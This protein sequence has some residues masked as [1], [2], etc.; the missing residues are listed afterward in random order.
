MTKNARNT[1]QNG[2]LQR[3]T[4][5]KGPDVWVFRYRE[6]G[7]LKYRVLG[8]VLQFKTKAAAQQALGDVK[9]N[10]N[11]RL[12]GATFGDL[13]DRYLREGLPER[14]ATAS[15]LRSMVKYR[16]K[17]YWADV[18]VSEMAADPMSVEQWIKNLQ[19]KPRKKD[20][21]PRPL[22]PK[23]KS[24]TKAV[25]HRLFECAMRWRYLTIQRN[26]MSLIEIPGASRR[27]RKIV[28]VPTAKYQMLLPKLPQHC[29][30]MVTLAMC[31]GLRISEILGLRWEDVDLEGG[32][33]QI[34]R[35]VVGGR[36][37]NTKTDASEDELPLHPQLVQVL[38]EWLEAEKP[39]EGWLFGNLDTGKP[40]HA[41][42]MRQRHLNKA[43]ADPEIGL[44][45]LGW[46][47]FRHTYR[48]NLSET[49]LP[50]EVQQKLM[51]HADIA[52]T[53][54]Y[55]RNSM[56]TVTRPANARIVEMV[57]EGGQKKITEAAA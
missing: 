2:C 42:T 23:S 48:A 51:R 31:L 27:V 43:A 26:P 39:V 28:L 47:A 38:R 1:Y 40:F 14:H 18:L 53:T 4:R 20:E 11:S 57:M 35:S 25:F 46:H 29:R 36:A 7:A 44:P 52:M 50:L 16:I 41:D 34:R 49:G 3:E 32:K 10:I 15:A 6:D 21:K 56:L 8:T 30:V 12:D 33:L 13:C 24:H 22:A 19:T 37:E 54:K 5:K 55:G 9:A 45:K 17:P